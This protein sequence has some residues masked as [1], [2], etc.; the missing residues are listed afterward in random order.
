MASR[1]MLATRV[2]C[3]ASLS[4]RPGVDFNLD[5]GGAAG[6]RSRRHAAICAAL[7]SER[8]R[9]RSSS[10]A[11]KI[12][13]FSWLIASV[14]AVIALALTT[15]NVRR[16]SRGPSTRG[17]PWWVAARALRAASKASLESLLPP[18]RRDGRS[19]RVASRTPLLCGG[20]ESGQAGA[21][22]AASLQDPDRLGQAAPLLLIFGPI[23]QLPVADGRGRCRALGKYRADGTDQA[24]AVGVGV[25]VDTDHGLDRVGKCLGHPGRVTRHRANGIGVRSNMF[26]SKRIGSDDGIAAPA[27]GVFCGSISAMRHAVADGCGGRA[28]DQASNR[29]RAGAGG[30]RDES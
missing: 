26:S 6:T 1:R 30:R 7:V 25:G 18:G 14:R 21:V 20:Q 3:S 4:T 22:T 8:S 11:C 15:S 27:R 28:P 29:A 9:S 19:G 5:R 17:W 24:G 16:A 12:S 23:H 2:R 10:G 13:D